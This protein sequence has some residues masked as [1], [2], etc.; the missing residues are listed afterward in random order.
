MLPSARMSALRPNAD[1]ATDK[2]AEA[3]LCDPVG[4]LHQLAGGGVGI[5]KLAGFDEFH[6]LAFIDL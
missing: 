4:D 2:T 3:R 6:G 5:S 1:N